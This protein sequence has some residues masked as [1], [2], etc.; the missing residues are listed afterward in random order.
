[1]QA[2]IW[3]DTDI[4]AGALWENEIQKHLNNSQIILLL[5]SP[6]F[7][8]SDYCFSMEMKRALERHALGEA[9]VIL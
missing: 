9:S 6:D 3:A 4:N 2:I 5:A 8:D 7:I 1:M